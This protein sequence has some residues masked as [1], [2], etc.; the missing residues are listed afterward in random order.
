MKKEPRDRMSTKRIFHAIKLIEAHGTVDG[1][2]YVY[3]EGW[4]DARIAAEVGCAEASVAHRRKAAFG[5]LRI[6]PPQTVEPTA[7]LDELRRRVEV[8]ERAVW[9]MQPRPALETTPNGT[10]DV[11]RPV[12]RFMTS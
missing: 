11:A 7:G 5:K 2:R 12:P 9:A 4:D 8:L 10:A 6:D 3:A 1:E